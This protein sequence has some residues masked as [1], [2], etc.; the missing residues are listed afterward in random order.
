MTDVVGTVESVV[1]W[2]VKS[3]G[4]GVAVPEVRA[5]ARGLVGDRA[6]ALVDRRPL[7]AGNVLSARNVP[8]ILRWSVV[9]LDDDEP[10]LAAPDG[11][12]WRWSDPGLPGALSDDLGVPVGLTGR[13]AHADLVDSVLVTTLATHAG[14][15]EGYGRPLDR[16]RWRTNLHLDL[17]APAFAEAGWEGRH[18]VVGEVR[19]RLLHPCKRCTIPSWSPDGRERS[20]DLLAFFHGD[21]GRRTFGINARVVE[22]G[23]VRAGDEVALQ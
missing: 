18:L 9:R 8:G 13:G 17:S 11:R 14:V 2:P 4:G 23:T 3:M 19:F 7:R 10:V 12:S 6:W 22:P 20:P 16:R 5:E 15:E 1:V 21:G